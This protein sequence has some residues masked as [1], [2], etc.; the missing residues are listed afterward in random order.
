MK[1]FHALCLSLLCAT[2]LSSTPAR[3]GAIDALHDAQEGRW[4]AAQSEAGNGVAQDIVLWM[5]L[6]DGDTRAPFSQ[7]AAFVADHPD[8]PDVKRL[9]KVA[10]TRLPDGISDAQALN[11]FAANPP[12]SAGGMTRYMSALLNQRQTALAVT[13]LKDWWV[14]ADISAADQNDILASYGQYLGTADHVRRLQRILTDRQYDA[15]RALA[16]RIGGS[17]PQLVE[18]RYALQEGRDGV[19]AQL[20]RLPRDLRDDAGL[21][22][23]RVQYRRQNNLDSEAV[24]LLDQAPPA[25]QTTD[26]AAWW[27]E[28]NIMARRMLEGGHYREAYKLASQHGLPSSG[29]DFATAEFLSGWIALRYLNDPGRAFDHFEHLYNNSATP[30]TKS[31]AAYWAGRASEALN[32]RDVAVQWYQVAAR[33]QTA[34]YGQLAA[35]RIGLPLTLIKG[36]KPPVSRADRSAFN[37]RSLVQAAALFHRAGM[38]RERTKFLRALLD[39][40]QSPQ[41]YTQVSDFAVSM[42]Q[43]DMALKV[44][45]EAEKTGLYLTD[46]AYPTIMQTVGD[47]G[48][49]KALVHALIR[50]ESQFDASAV[51]SSGALGLMQIMPA[52]GQHTAKRNDLMHQTAW[53]T[54]NPN[55]NVKIGS[56]YIA[57]LLDKYQGCLPLAIAAYNA[58]PGRVNQWINEFGDPRD[59]RI[60]MVDWIESIPVYETRNYVQRVMEGYSVYR[61]K[62]A[63]YAS[64]HQGGQQDGGD[65]FVIDQPAGNAP[66]TSYRMRDASYERGGD[67]GGVYVRRYDDDSSGRPHGYSGMRA[68]FNQ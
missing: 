22:L 39:S 43:V 44:A 53:L 2:F 9:L 68:A 18:A 28:R 38:A 37:N 3:A 21:L 65:T 57:E 17:Y 51:S 50:Q 16:P 23:S 33:F 24:A 14:N 20:S 59:Q 30:I 5:Y 54:S 63:R 67:Q 10:E 13:T 62:L 41:D 19:E 26:P 4:S 34:F 47:Y 46:Y 25:G 7:I 35:Q 15:A 60:D 45:K 8:W 66:N 31:R 56:L 40:A 55:H 52:T 58:G 49:D 12:V 1:R 64:G 29:Q 42:G 48:V 32:G 6:L 11:W 61:M 27:K 36:E